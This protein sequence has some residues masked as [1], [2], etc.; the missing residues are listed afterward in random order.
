MT[1]GSIKFVARQTV[2]VSAESRSVRSDVEAL[3]EFGGQR[4]KTTD[5]IR[6][7]STSSPASRIDDADAPIGLDLVQS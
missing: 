7:R 1:E 3:I 6:L 5:D 2:V 4:S